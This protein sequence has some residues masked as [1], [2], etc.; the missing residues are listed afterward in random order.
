MVEL[1]VKGEGRAGAGLWALALAVAARRRVAEEWQG[2]AG[3]S[4]RLQRARAPKLTATP[5]D[6]RP[7]DPEIGR[8]LLAGRMVLAGAELEVGPGGDPWDRASPT[9]RFAVELH[10]FAFLPHLIASGEAGGRE[11]LKL[12]LDWRRMFH[13][14]NG[15]VWSAEV[16]ERRVFN[17]AAGAR[18]MGTLASDVEA[19][20]LTGSLLHQA[21]VL[22]S[23]P[24]DPARA[25]ERA[26]TA[27]V[28]AGALAGSGA[29]RLLEQAQ[30]RLG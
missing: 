5:R 26:S 16:L 1:A 6:F 19:A 20:D 17:L 23:L 27:A 28:A 29:E 24:G 2:R 8:A 9:R 13:R 30:T 10:R 12:F 7:A 14:P 25:A 21:Q 22:L 4:H 11:A 18:R 15:F 3:G